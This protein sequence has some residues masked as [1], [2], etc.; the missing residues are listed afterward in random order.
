MNRLNLILTVL[1][2]VQAAALTA[3]NLQK[4]DGAEVQRTKVLDGVTSDTLSRLEI[5]DKDGSSITLEKGAEGWV[6]PALGGYPAAASKVDAIIADL[7]GLEV[8]KPMSESGDHLHDLEVADGHFRKKI[9]VMAG[10]EETLLYV[11]TSARTGGVHL[12]KGGQSA[13]YSARDLDD[14]RLAPRTDAWIDVVAWDVDAT[15]LEGL[16]T[17]RSGAVLEL[18]KGAGGW[19]AN[20]GV[21]PIVADPQKLDS[22]ARQ[23]A[24]VTFTDVAGRFDSQDWGFATPVATITLAIRGEKEGDPATTR[25]LVVAEVPGD[26]NKFRLRVD[27]QPWVLVASSWAIDQIIGTDAAELAPDPPKAD[28]MPGEE[29]AAPGDPHAHVPGFGGH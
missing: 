17:E 18:K 12:R 3:R 1:L 16:R 28:P 19:E 14:W 23:A 25:R 7:V 6:L 5:H 29:M 24:R 8:R 2:L 20:D 27:D 22:R 11:G 15:R 9:R 4:D 10:T 21:A 13:V 26:K